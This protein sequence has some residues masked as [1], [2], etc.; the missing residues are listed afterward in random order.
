MLIY[1]AQAQSE[2][3]RLLPG[4]PKLQTQ[5]SIWSRVLSATDTL[6]CGKIVDDDVVSLGIKQLCVC[7]SCMM[8]LWLVSFVLIM[9]EILQHKAF[10]K[11]RITLF[12]PMWAGSIIGILSIV[13][14]SV[15]VCRNATLIS[16]E[17]RLYMRQQG[18]ET[19]SLFIDYDSL[20]LMRRLFCWNISLCITFLLLLI[21][22][23]LFSLWFIYDLI[24]LWHALIPVVILLCAYLCY[25]YSMA[26]MSVTGCWFSTFAALQLVSA[27]IPLKLSAM[28]LVFSFFLFSCIPVF[29]EYR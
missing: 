3:S 6:C 4:S 13:V 19:S 5:P 28:L 11:E 27:L 10:T 21:A 1:D 22:Q 17:R 24:G 26:F 12:I 15:R 20:P 2:Q 23:V 9:L 29:L 14:I 18:T 8:G 16:K 7:F 25:L